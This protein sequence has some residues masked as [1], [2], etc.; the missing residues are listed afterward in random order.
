MHGRRV[1]R[2]SARSF[3]SRSHTSI[4]PGQDDAYASY[5]KLFQEAS[6]RVPGSDTA[7]QALSRSW[8]KYITVVLPFDKRPCPKSQCAQ[9]SPSPPGNINTV[10]KADHYFL[11]CSM[12][13][14][15]I[16]CRTKTLP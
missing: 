14:S 7:Q 1:V 4:S 9:A 16:E 11:G 6:G 2:Q 12:Y 5:E 13:M 10:T 15:S 8:D 3:L